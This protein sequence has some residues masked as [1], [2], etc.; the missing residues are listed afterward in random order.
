MSVRGAEAATAGSARM[1]FRTKLLKM[2]GSCPGGLGQAD[3]H[4]VGTVDA[5]DQGPL[6]PVSVHARGSNAHVVEG[7]AE[8]ALLL[9]EPQPALVDVDQL[10]A[11]GSTHADRVRH[12]PEV[13][14]P[15][16]VDG[17][18]GLERRGGALLSCQPELL[19][20]LGDVLPG[21]QLRVDGEV[22]DERAD[23]VGQGLRVHEPE[24]HEEE[25]VF[26]V[27]VCRGGIAGLPQP[28]CPVD[29]PP[30]QGAMRRRH[31]NAS[32]IGVERVEAVLW[33]VAKAPSAG[34]V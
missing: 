22:Q 34:R 21:I 5:H 33:S 17:R 11:W 13:L 15:R 4:P 3:P 25:L 19:L 2:A 31:G 23:L 16:K 20:A 1:V 18:E 6:L 24:D 14:A 7:L 10:G 26:A 30:I 28:R 8:G 29:T 27:Q 12:V 9:L 32:L